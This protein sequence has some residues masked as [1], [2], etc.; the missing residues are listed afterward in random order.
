MPTSTNVQLDTN[1]WG[2][3]YPA[4]ADVYIAYYNSDAQQH[5]YGGRH[6]LGDLNNWS[7]ESF[8]ALYPAAVPGSIGYN[9]P[10]V[11]AEVIPEPA[12]LTLLGTA[13]LGFGVVYLRRR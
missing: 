12:T 2:T 6:W 7:P 3:P 9:D 13:L 8:Q 1:P 4:P 11:I 10:W 5:N